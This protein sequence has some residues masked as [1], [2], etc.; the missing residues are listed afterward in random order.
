MFDVGIWEI[1]VIGVVALVVLGPERL[2]KV[3]R[4][5]GHLFGRMQRYV[6]NV[7]ADINREMDASEFSKVKEEVQSA[8]RSF[9]QTMNDQKNLI[10][11]ESHAVSQLGDEINATTASLTDAPT[12]AQADI[13]LSQEAGI[14]TPTVTTAPSTPPQRSATTYAVAQESLQSFDLGIEPPRVLARARIRT[15]SRER[16]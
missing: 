14:P 4:T 8:A 7:K 10:E 15:Q 9:E 12:N 1:G 16:A 6:A 5:A 3:A 11:S 13:L 2:P